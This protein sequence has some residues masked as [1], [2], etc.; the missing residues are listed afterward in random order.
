MTCALCA[1]RMFFFFSPFNAA[2]AA[3]I[4]AVSRGD[5][6]SI[7]TIL[8][9][10]H[11]RFLLLHS[12]GGPPPHARFGLFHFHSVSIPIQIQLIN[13]HFYLCSMRACVCASVPM[14][15]PTCL[16][17]HDPHSIA[18]AAAMPMNG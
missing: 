18:A 9:S 2:T 16:L 1:V 7:S 14:W 12:I 13:E 11:R 5:C 6:C 15:L 17:V 10:F 4:V 8:F 3:A